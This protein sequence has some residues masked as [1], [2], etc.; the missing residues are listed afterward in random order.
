MAIAAIFS[1][2]YGCHFFTSGPILTKFNGN[3]ENG[4]NLTPNA[5]VISKIHIQQSTKIKVAVAAILNSGNLLPFL[6]Y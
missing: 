1:F 4:E 5:N 3:V 6:C 2:E